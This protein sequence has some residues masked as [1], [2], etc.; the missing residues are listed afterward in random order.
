IKPAPL[1]RM[2]I[3]SPLARR[4]S[5]SVLRPAPPSTL[6]S[7]GTAAI[8]LQPSASSTSARASTIPSSADSSP[9]LPSSPPRTVTPSPQTI[10]STTPIQRDYSPKSQLQNAVLTT[11][12]ATTEVRLVRPLKSRILEAPSTLTILRAQS[13]KA[14]TR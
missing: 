7:S 11:A 5:S 4:Y 1:C 10:P 3:I 6:Q 9:P 13:D 12:V 8:S 14:V 2:S